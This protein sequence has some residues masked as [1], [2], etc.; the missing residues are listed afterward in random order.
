[1]STKSGG[2]VAMHEL[3]NHFIFNTS[4]TMHY[5]ANENGMFNFPIAARISVFLSK[6]MKVKGLIGYGKSL[7]EDKLNM[8]SEM[9]VGEGKTNTWYIGGL[10]SNSALTFFIGNS[11]K[12]D[13][14]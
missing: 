7:K 1:M 6:D 3:F 10:Q 14:K 8:A 12:E 4:F 2:L 5:E 13:L 11:E 9:E